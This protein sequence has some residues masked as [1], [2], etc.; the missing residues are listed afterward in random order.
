[1]T[2]AAPENH[3]GNSI[4]LFWH[5]YRYF[6]Y[7]RELGLKEVEHLLKP[8]RIFAQ[9]D[10]VEIIKIGVDE[11][12]LERLVYFSAFQTNG[13]KHPTY[14]HL[15][16]REDAGDARRQG[17]RYSVHGL[18][19]YKGKFNP[20]VVRGILNLLGVSDG[21][22][23]LDPFCGSGT[24]LVECSHVGLPSAG[25]DTNPFA[26]FISSTKL[27]ALATPAKSL[28]QISDQIID[29]LSRR[30]LPGSDRSGSPERS[31]YLSKWFTPDMLDSIENVR[32]VIQEDAHRLSHIYLAL[33]SNLLRDYS[34]QDPDDL[35][36][37]RRR[38]PLP[39]KP[40]HMAVKEAFEGFLLKLEKTQRVMGLRPRT[41]FAHPYDARELDRHARNWKLLPPFDAAITSPP[42]ATALP[43]ID[44]QRLSL[45]WLELC[46]PSDL[47][48]R[49]AQ[50]IGSREFYR[51][52]RSLWVETMERNKEGLPKDVLLVCR[53]L[54][55][56]LTNSD[57][58]RRQVVPILLYRYFS[59]MQQAF[60]SVSRVMKKRAPFALI[61][62]HN[63]TVLGGRRF[64]I[65]TPDLL[66]K[67]AQSVGWVLETQTKLQTYQRY[68][69]H[70]GNAIECETLLV[71]R[72]S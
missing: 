41:G 33:V 64:D 46:Q 43:Y 6:P 63:H 21:D 48:I 50:L 8:Q 12:S 45:I 28:R 44:T 71:L 53:K 47:A 11:R 38:T 49:E 5:P 30:H 37:R 58:F 52:E 25:C 39:G 1:M 29:S 17:T 22:K 57:G 23:I 54:R 35:R 36:I 10:C 4:R 20:Q 14:Q 3:T 70:C 18:H 31:E 66:A 68:G 15:I 55:D 60:V 62:G 7:E 59:D 65:D 13:I 19:E 40:F 24:T 27:D 26:T 34:L 42:Y 72:N 9:E 56:A 2:T 61:V 51:Q 32:D 67:L 16:E 69:V